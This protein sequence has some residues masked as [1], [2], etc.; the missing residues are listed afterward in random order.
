MGYNSGFKGLNGLYVIHNC[1][2]FKVV[3]GNEAPDP[4]ATRGASRCARLDIW[5]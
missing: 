2:G 3:S 4:A 1:L 5:F